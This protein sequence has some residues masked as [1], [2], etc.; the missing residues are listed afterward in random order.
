M[1]RPKFILYSDQALAGIRSAAVVAAT[2]LD[3]IC[4]FVRPGMSTGELDRYAGDVIQQ[5]GARSAF[6]NYKGFP[7]QVCISLNDEIVH[8]IGCNNRIM[9][10]GDLVKIDC[11]V[12][13]N[14]YVG[15][16]ARSVALGPPTAQATRLM[17]ATQESLAAGIA[18]AKPGNTVCDIGRAVEKV[19]RTAGFTVVR[20]FVGHG[21]GEAL[22]EPPEVPNFPT[23]RANTK[24]RPGMVLAIE[25]MVNVGTANVSHDDDGWTVRTQ[26]G[27]LSSHFEHMIAITM[28]EAEIL[29]WPKTQSE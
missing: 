22:H 2:A 15:D 24:L 8:G 17:Q 12:H 16:N 13:Y 21:V 5:L 11:G 9:R 6:L 14:G 20:E 27:A 28:N 4:R 1:S 26:D 7:G 29:T 18:A 10:L 23:R 25:P 3:R 19:V